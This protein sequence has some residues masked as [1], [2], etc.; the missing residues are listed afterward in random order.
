LVHFVE[1]DHELTDFSSA[2]SSTDAEYEHPLRGVTA[3]STESTAVELSL[4]DSTAQS[5]SVSKA[6]ESNEDEVVV[7]KATTAPADSGPV[8]VRLSDASPAGE[9]EVV[10]P[11]PSAPARR[12]LLHSLGI[13]DDEPHAPHEHRPAARPSRS[14]EDES[15]GSAPRLGGASNLQNAPARSK[16]PRRS[17]RTSLSALNPFADRSDAAGH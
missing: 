15:G 6:A 2:P 12:G 13:L 5:G 3:A 16:P 8:R 4:S 1:S 9:M 10:R 11:A 14:M 17:L 7:R